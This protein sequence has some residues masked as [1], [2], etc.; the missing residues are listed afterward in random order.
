MET[1][2]F[3]LWQELSNIPEKL[4][5]R[6]NRKSIRAYDTNCNIIMTSQTTSLNTAIKSRK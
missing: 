1:R 3:I 6:H 4:L 5:L 2:L